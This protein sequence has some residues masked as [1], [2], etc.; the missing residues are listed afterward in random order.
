M[1]Y[2]HV[3]PGLVSLYS[4][5]YIQ[6]DRDRIRNNL[7]KSRLDASLL[8]PPPGLLSLRCCYDVQ[9]ATVSPRR[10]LYSFV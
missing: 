6:R 1:Q 5:V 7:E 9:E 2:N 4:V 3:S 8:C 10:S